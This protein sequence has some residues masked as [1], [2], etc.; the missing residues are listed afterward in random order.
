MLGTVSL[1]RRILMIPAFNP[2]NNYYTISG[3]DPEFSLGGGGGAQKIICA[4][5]H[6]EREIR[7]PFRQGSRARLRA[8]EA[9]GVF[10][11]L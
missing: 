11:A 2:Q 8:L 10:N 6:Y 5:A 4:N 7:S 3:T 1:P 9:L